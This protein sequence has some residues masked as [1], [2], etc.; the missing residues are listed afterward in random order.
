MKTLIVDDEEDMRVLMRSIIQI[1]N[2]GLEVA[3]EASDGAEALEQ[4]RALQPDVVVLDQRMPGMTG[5]EVA[6]AILA[7][8][9]ESKLV[10][11]T[12]FLSPAVRAEAERLGMHAVLSKEHDL[13]IRLAS[14]LHSLAA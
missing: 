3:G 2:R 10:L 9:P 7:E 13:H 1:A 11:V 4:W 6:K 12:A 14:T 8:A 5:L